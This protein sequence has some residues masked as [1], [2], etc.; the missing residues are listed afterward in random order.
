MD[1]YRVECRTDMEHST[2]LLSHYHLT[3][4]V[5]QLRMHSIP[6]K[7]PKDPRAQNKE[8]PLRLHEFSIP[9]ASSVEGRKGQ[10]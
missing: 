10:L 5:Y 4:E 8:V 7:I 3:I 9:S 6:C 2:V 1:R